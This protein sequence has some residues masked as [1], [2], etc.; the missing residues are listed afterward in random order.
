MEFALDSPK[1]EVLPV[2]GMW[3]G[4]MVKGATRAAQQKEMLARTLMELE[5]GFQ[6]QGTR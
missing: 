3:T 2:P 4:Q 5:Q 6:I 1:L